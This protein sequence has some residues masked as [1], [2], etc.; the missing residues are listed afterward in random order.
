MKQWQIPIHEMQ[1]LLMLWT[2]EQIKEQIHT[3]SDWST[4]ITTIKQRSLLNCL[5]DIPKV[6]HSTY[7]CLTKLYPIKD[8]AAFEQCT[9]TPTH[10][11]YFHTD[12]KAVYISHNTTVLIQYMD[13]VSLQHSKPTYL[14][15]ALLKPS[16]QQSHVWFLENYSIFQ[17]ITDIAAAWEVTKKC[18]TGIWKEE[19]T[20]RF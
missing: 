20:R 2:E 15:C 13:Q 12:I 5:K 4:T 11:D 17:G 10:S 9:W 8:F 14:W 19:H 18:M 7:L 6:F 16:L 3:Y 1:F